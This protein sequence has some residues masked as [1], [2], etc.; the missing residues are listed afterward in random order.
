MIC[1]TIV[2]KLFNERNLNQQST[3]STLPKLSFNDYT[4]KMFQAHNDD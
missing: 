1:S 4:E 2:K 3:Q